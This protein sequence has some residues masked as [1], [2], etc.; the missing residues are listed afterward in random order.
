MFIVKS[1]NPF[2][3]ARVEGTSS[4]NLVI[5]TP[6][7]GIKTK[8]I[9]PFP[10]FVLV[11]YPWPKFFGTHTLLKTQAKQLD[12]QDLSKI[13]VIIKRGRHR[14]HKGNAEIKLIISK[15]NSAAQKEN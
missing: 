2:W 1:T 10:E 5:F 8:I 3:F 14:T 12:F 9:M 15:M 11:F 6:T 13:G 4:T 7:K